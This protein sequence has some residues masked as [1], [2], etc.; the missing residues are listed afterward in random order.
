MAHVRYTLRLRREIKSF[1]E[2]VE[3]TSLSRNLSKRIRKLK[4]IEFI[5]EMLLLNISKRKLCNF[6]P[7]REPK[8]LL[9]DSQL[10]KMLPDLARKRCLLRMINSELSQLTNQ[11]AEQEEEL[12]A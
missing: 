6:L 11:E 7:M 4:L 2:L 3:A 9:R 12:I 5:E 10:I 1:A 8:L